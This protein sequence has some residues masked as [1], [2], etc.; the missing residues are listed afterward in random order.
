VVD[1]ANLPPTCIQSVNEQFRQIASIVGRSESAQRGRAFLR[2][3]SAL[4]V[5]LTVLQSG[6]SNSLICFRKSIRLR[7]RSD[8]LMQKG[9]LDA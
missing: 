9:T 8:C 3:K 2:A 6:G 5:G 7:F 4:P 1:E